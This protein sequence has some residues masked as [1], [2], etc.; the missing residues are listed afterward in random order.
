[1]SRLRREYFLK[2]L[3]LTIEPLEKMVKKQIIKSFVDV[4]R[5]GAV[6]QKSPWPPEAFL[7]VPQLTIDNSQLSIKNF[8]L[9]I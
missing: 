4:S 2:A 3:P 5:T 6:F 1:L 9:K 7:Q 8:I